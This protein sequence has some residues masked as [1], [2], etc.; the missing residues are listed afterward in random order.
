MWPK[1]CFDGLWCDNV[2]MTSLLFW[3]P[4]DWKCILIMACAI[5]WSETITNFLVTAAHLVSSYP[6]ISSLQ[7]DPASMKSRLSECLMISQQPVARAP[8]K[9]PIS[10]QRFVTT[11]RRWQG[12]RAH[13]SSNLSTTPARILSGFPGS[14]SCLPGDR[15]GYGTPRAL[16]I[17][18][19][20]RYLLRSWSQ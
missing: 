13:D 3:F 17:R 11:A 20:N 6:F 5:R 1:T 14:P 4:Y 16:V 10:K 12:C 19:L 2:A 9:Y 8:C 18:T 7:I 15:D